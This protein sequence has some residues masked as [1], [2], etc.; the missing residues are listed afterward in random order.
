VTKGLCETAESASCDETVLVTVLGMAAKTFPARWWLMTGL[1]ALFVALFAV[2]LYAKW[3]GGG[4]CFSSGA[5][6]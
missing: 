4:R 3:P 6:A 5:S 1:A 2:G